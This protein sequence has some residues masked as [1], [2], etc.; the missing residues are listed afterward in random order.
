[1]AWDF[2]RPPGSQV[3]ATAEVKFLHFLKVPK[4]SKEPP[5]KKAK[6]EDR[7]FKMFQ[8]TGQ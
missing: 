3:L 5:Q 1:M 4:P 2:Q 7:S 8:E 6:S